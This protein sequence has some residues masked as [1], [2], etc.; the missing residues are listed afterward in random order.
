[1]LVSNFSDSSAEITGTILSDQLP[2]CLKLR[3]RMV[4][5]MSKQMIVAENYQY[6]FF[7]MGVEWERGIY[8]LITVSTSKYREE[9]SLIKQ[10]YMPKS[11]DY[12]ALTTN[13][14]QKHSNNK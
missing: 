11:K 4:R 1:M 7:R 14:S 5:K 12:Q 13:M 2:S 8:L 9:E 6:S 10:N 3:M